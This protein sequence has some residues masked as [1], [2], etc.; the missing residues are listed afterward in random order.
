M[1]GQTFMQ[2]PRGRRRKTL[3]EI[4]LS[5]LCYLPYIPGLIKN[6]AISVPLMTKM[7]NLSTPGLLVEDVR[8]PKPPLREGRH[9]P[10]L[11]SPG[12]MRA[13]PPAEA[14]PMP[15]V[16]MFPPTDAPMAA[17]QTRRTA[18]VRAGDARTRTGSP[19]P[20]WHVP[21]AAAPSS[22]PQKPGWSDRHVTGP[23]CRHNYIENAF[24][25]SVG[26]GSNGLIFY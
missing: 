14:A 18:P 19:S 23:V 17:A 10:R 2:D 16:F 25:A 20:G 12:D 4:Q 8:S 9:L 3:P 6:A 11:P 15:R 7:T 1:Q 22:V 5:Y 13:L 26:N 24:N 21:S